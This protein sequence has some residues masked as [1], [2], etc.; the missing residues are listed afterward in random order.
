MTT[1]TDDNEVRIMTNLWFQCKFSMLNPITQSVV[2]SM[3]S[4]IIVM[5]CHNGRPCTTSWDE[6]T[7]R[8]SITMIVMMTHFYTLTWHS[9]LDDDNG[10]GDGDDYFSLLFSFLFSFIYIYLP[11]ALGWGLGIYFLDGGH[12][13]PYGWV[14]RSTSTSD[15]CLWIN[16]SFQIWCHVLHV[17]HISCVMSSLL[18]FR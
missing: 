13:Q 9:C 18:F 1:F 5:G 3:V 2:A 4:L 6:V 12:I 17:E 8:V 16:P 15:V 14:F 11:K 7:I 10:D